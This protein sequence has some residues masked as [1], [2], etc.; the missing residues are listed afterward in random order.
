MDEWIHIPSHSSL[1]FN[2]ATLEFQEQHGQKVFF[3]HVSGKLEPMGTLCASYHAVTDG[4]ILHEFEKFWKPYWQRDERQEQFQD[5]PWEPFMRKLDQGF[6]PR[7]PAISMDMD[8]IAAWMALIRKLPSNKAVGPCGW[9]NEDLKSLPEICIVD[10]VKI[11]N[12]VMVYG[13]SS[14][15]MMAKTIL[16]SKRESTV[17]A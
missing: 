2:D 17:D 9:S 11:F 7:F 4:E 10:L 15:M 13:F 12:Y 3:R 6:L 14:N 8:N 1:Q 5:E 16:L